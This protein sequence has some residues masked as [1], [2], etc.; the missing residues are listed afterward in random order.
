MP[1]QVYGVPRLGGVLAL[2]SLTAEVRKA[3]LPRFVF[4]QFVRPVQGYGKNKGDE[5]RFPRRSGLAGSGRRLAETELIPVTGFT[6]DYGTLLVDEY[7]NAAACTLRLTTLAEIDI[8][9]HIV[10]ALRDDIVAT[11]DKEIAAVAK[12]TKIKYVPTSPTGG[13]FLTN[14]EFK[15]S[16][17]NPVVATSNL[18][19]A[20]VK[21]IVDYL[22][23]YLHVPGYDGENYVCVLTTKARRGIIDDSNFV[24]AAHYGDPERLFR[25]EIGLLYNTRF[26]HCNNPDALNNAVGQNGV[27]GE[28]L[29]FAD[30][31]LVEGVALPEEIRS[32]TRDLGR[33]TVIGWIYMGG[34]ALTW[35]S[36]KP[37]EC[38]VIHVGSA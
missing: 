4:R 37:G 12:K 14:G 20:H 6:I 21:D 31:P 8:Q 11:M 25:Y 24:Q 34:W 2:P 28:A 38:R 36:N 19:T 15:D 30:D 26:V 16:N 27:L 18:T 5:I 9:P 7:G 13:V 17:G 33:Q 35:D 22:Q 3:A 32:E 1:A 29:F 10:D 23:G